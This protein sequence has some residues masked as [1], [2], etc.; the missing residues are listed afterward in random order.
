MKLPRGDTDFCALAIR[1]IT[2][3]NAAQ[4]RCV[5]LEISDQS[6]LSYMLTKVGWQVV[7]C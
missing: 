7:S 2:C 5:M 3:K 4:K 6:L 1:T